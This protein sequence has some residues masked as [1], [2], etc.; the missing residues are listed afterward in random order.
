MCVHK[1]SVRRQWSSRRGA[2]LVIVDA[3]GFFFPLKRI[4]FIGLLTFTCSVTSFSHYS[5]FPCLFFP[6]V[7]QIHC[8][9]NTLNFDLSPMP[10]LRSQNLAFSL[11]FYVSRVSSPLDSPLKLSAFLSFLILSIFQAD[12]WVS[13]YAEVISLWTQSQEHIKHH[14]LVRSEVSE[15]HHWQ[16]PSQ[17]SML[18]V[19]SDN[20]HECLS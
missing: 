13:D 16:T 20:T 18:T 7:C 2:A 9:Q 1:Q 6:S 4:S 5:S 11:L 3:A 19:D 14:F 8:K 17:T 15:L 10:P 12:H